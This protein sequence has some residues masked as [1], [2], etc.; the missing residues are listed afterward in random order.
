M[1]RISKMNIYNGLR[2]MGKGLSGGSEEMRHVRLAERRADLPLDKRH[3][4]SVTHRNFAL[5]TVL[6]TVISLYTH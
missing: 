6:H 4:S 5:H 3:S 2:G 1:G